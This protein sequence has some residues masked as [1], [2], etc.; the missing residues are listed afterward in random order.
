[1]NEERNQ[2]FDEVSF[3]QH[4]QEFIRFYEKHKALCDEIAGVKTRAI[5]ENGNA[6]PIRITRSNFDYAI[7]RL[8][9]FIID[10]IH[11]IDEKTTRKSIMAKFEKLEEDFYYNKKYTDFIRREKAL[12]VSEDVEFNK[13]YF[14]YVLRCFSLSYDF[15]KLLQSS[16]MLSTADVKKSLRFYDVSAFFDNLA[17][18]RDEVSLDLSNIKLKTTFQHLKKVIAYNYTYRI[19]MNREEIEYIDELIII[20]CSY[21][22]NSEFL[23]FMRRH[24]LK[25]V[26]TSEEIMNI[27]K[28]MKFIKD[29]LG[30]IYILT[31][32]SLSERNILPKIEQKTYIDKTL[33]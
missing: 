6:I 12:N 22:M 16:L 3:S 5:I 30:T 20:V 9:A 11:Y 28:K 1:M 2:K 10:C 8:G 24:L 26:L 25:E 17:K 18:Y 4:I 29:I 33:I 13:M 31:N 27:R 15:F 14:D 19:F 32:E 23:D 7:K 21:V